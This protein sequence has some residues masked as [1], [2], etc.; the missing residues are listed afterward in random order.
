MTL[1]FVFFFFKI[2][3]TL[4]WVSCILYIA[5][6][7][8]VLAIPNKVHHRA[9]GLV[10]KSKKFL[11]DNIGSKMGTKAQPKPAR[12]EIGKRFLFFFVF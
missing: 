6:Q 12:R 3:Q 1:F 8:N 10:A 11:G 5:K 9:E 4:F 2:S 7:E